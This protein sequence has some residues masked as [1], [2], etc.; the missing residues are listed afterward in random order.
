MDETSPP[1]A[2]GD[3]APVWPLADLKPKFAK[4]SFM[5]DRK[6]KSGTRYHAG[7]DLK[8]PRGTVVVAME[9][10]TV[11]KTQTF[12]GPTAYA[13]LLEVDSTGIVLNYG[14]V[15]PDSWEEFGV[16]PGVHV[17]KGDP[18][19]RVGMNPKGDTM[20]HF[21]T[22]APGTR[23]TSSWR[24]GEPAPPS[25]LNPTQ[26]LILASGQPID[27][28]LNPT[29]TYPGSPSSATAAGGGLFVFLGALAFQWWRSRRRG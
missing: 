20:I 17:D 14:E 9:G 23:K 28:N 26:Y 5:R 6:G 3:A 7:V 11:V 8:A 15:E 1:Y 27:H 25:L 10:G 29:P 13:L 4:D 24:H 19:A 16:A 21:E 2:E 12:N 22:Y 18:I